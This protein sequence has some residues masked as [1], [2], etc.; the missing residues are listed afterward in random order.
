MVPS[1][2]FSIPA[3]TVECLQM[4]DGP[5]ARL[6]GGHLGGHDARGTGTGDARRRDRHLHRDRRR[7]HHIPGSIWRRPVRI[8]QRLYREIASRMGS[9]S[10]D[11]CAS[12]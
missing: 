1:G 5:D 9:P 2:R 8:E 10:S 7:V 4:C 12:P 3:A 6:R 11:V